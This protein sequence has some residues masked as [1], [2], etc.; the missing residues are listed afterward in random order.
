[1]TTGVLPQ[2]QATYPADW[3]DFLALTKPRVMSLVVFTGLCGML[4]A[5]V[6]VN[7]VLG[8]T[9]IL[10]IALAA[11][12]AAAL[13]M[14][15]E[16][17]L[18]AKMKRTA[19]RPIPAGR[20]DR[21]S[22]LHFGVGLAFF[23]V[24]LMELATNRVAAAVLAVS[25]LFYVLVYTVWLKRRTPQNIVIGGAAGAFPPVIGWAAAT[26]NITLLPVLLF[27]LIFLWTPPHFW[28]L[29]LF[30]RSDYAAAGVPM[31]PVVAGPRTTRQHILLYSLP[32]AA[33]AVAPWPLGLAGPFYGIIAAAF[34]LVFVGIAVQVLLSRA[35]EPSE[36]KAEKRLF[37]F[38]I[39]YL[40][41]LFGA[42]V[43]DRWWLA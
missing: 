9:A 29:S 11:G 5:P 21:Q 20:M 37:A 31:L 14:W 12:A 22:A 1:M 26:G 42:L 2:S 17:D 4:A 24:I 33:A 6:R 38:S 30:V 8:F 41:A 36:M 7:P 15:Y 40:F 18:D 28:A 19:K 32:M 27:L 43:V 23:S 25:I 3:R 13:N 35:A 39:L 34:S 10:C 16:S